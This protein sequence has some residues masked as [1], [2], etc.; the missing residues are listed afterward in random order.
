M[1]DWECLR[2][3]ESQET[4]KESPDIPSRSELNRFGNVRT[5]RCVHMCERGGDFCYSEILAGAFVQ[6]LQTQAKRRAAVVVPEAGRGISGES[7]SVTPVLRGV[8]LPFEFS[9][10]LSGKSDAACF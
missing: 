9:S 6:L 10:S 8:Y 7:Q 4:N 1:T 2:A 3:L 5:L